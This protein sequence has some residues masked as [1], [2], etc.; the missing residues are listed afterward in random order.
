MECG[1]GSITLNALEQDRCGRSQQWRGV[2]ESKCAHV[3]TCDH[4]AW[5]RAPQCIRQRWHWRQVLQ[6]SFGESTGPWT[7]ENKEPNSPVSYKISATLYL[8]TYLLWA[9]TEHS[10]GQMICSACDRLSKLKNW[11]HT[12]FSDCW[13]VKVRNQQKIWGI[14]WI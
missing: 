5:T 2:R 4:F 8:A 13:T 10:L 7:Q 9:C 14:H 6:R 3:T 12:D 1:H 11:N